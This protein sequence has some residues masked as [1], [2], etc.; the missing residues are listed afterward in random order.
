MIGLKD[1]IKKFIYKYFVEYFL[2]K[3]SLFVGEYIK[4]LTGARYRVEA[5]YYSIELEPVIVAADIEGRLRSF[6]QRGLERVHEDS[7]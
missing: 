3:H 2:P 5:I 1:K 6:P 7:F 4:D